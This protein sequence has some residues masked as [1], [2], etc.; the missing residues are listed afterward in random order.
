MSFSKLFAVSALS[1]AVASCGGGGGGGGGSSGST[2]STTTPVAANLLTG[3]AASGAPLANATVT[4]W[5]QL[6]ADGGWL[7]CTTATTDANGNFQINLAAC[8]SL[9]SGFIAL[10]APDG[11]GNT[12]MSAYS[13]VMSAN[14]PVYVNLN[15]M[16]TVSVSAIGSNGA[17]V[18]PQMVL[19][20]LSALYQYFIGQG[21]TTNSA[22]ASTW[23]VLSGLEVT[24]KMALAQAATSVMNWNTWN[25]SNFFTTQFAANHTGFDAVIDSVTLFTNQTTFVPQLNDLA[26]NTL[27]LP[28]GYSP[29][30]PTGG[31]YSAIT[32][33]V[34]V[35]NAL[36]QAM[37]N[38]N[39]VFTPA[40][41]TYTGTMLANGQTTA[42]TCNLT[43]TF[44]AS[45]A[46]GSISGTCTSV[47]TGAVAISGSIQP[48]GLA[49]LNNTAGYQF[50]GGL[51]ASGGAGTWTKGNLSGTWAVH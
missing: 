47:A 34:S 22:L 37:I 48:N 23:S 32:L 17:A 21:F 6:H 50:T 33:P 3:V 8:P 12:L 36:S 7:P 28:T 16:T 11:H 9:G 18:T 43:G 20:S 15:P 45:P 1:L 39:T 2:S 35:Q 10:S 27:A 31:G 14:S 24:P 25:G 49:S 40:A 30:A 19:Y 29:T 51:T 26:G 5:N 4:A 42:G 44:A 13:P 38:P 46:T 41:H